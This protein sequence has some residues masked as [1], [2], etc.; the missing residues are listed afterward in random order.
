[1]PHDPK[2]AALAS[3]LR[4][5][6]TYTLDTNFAKVDRI[7]HPDIEAFK[8]RT[9]ETTFRGAKIKAWKKLL[10]MLDSPTHA[11]RPIAESAVKRELYGGVTP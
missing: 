6:L 10:S 8:T 2:T 5:I 9:L 4:R 7:A 1:M 3:S 11:K